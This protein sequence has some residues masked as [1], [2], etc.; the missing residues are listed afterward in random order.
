MCTSVPKA[1]ATERTQFVCTPEA[2][3]D[4]LSEPAIARANSIA[5][6]LGWGRRSD[7]VYA[8]AT[9]APALGSSPPSGMTPLDLLR[10]AG[11]EPVPSPEEETAR[12]SASEV[13]TDNTCGVVCATLGT[14]IRVVG[15][16]L[17][18]VADSANETGMASP[19]LTRLS[20]V[21]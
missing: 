18:Y 6:E 3:L 20:F 19:R 5:P 13:V 1:C 10:L 17:A 16:R 11:C 8:L 9:L 7:V 12:T 15:V 14:G 21:V 2:P 4:A